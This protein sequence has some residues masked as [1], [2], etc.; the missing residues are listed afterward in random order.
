MTKEIKTWKDETGREIPL[1]Y[2]TKTQK[3]REALAA[4][5]LKLSQKQHD[6]LKELKAQYAAICN[7]VY[8][9]ALAEYNV[10]Q[11]DRKGNFTWFNFD[12]SIK[13]ETNVNAQIKF[14][15]M[16]IGLCKDKPSWTH[17]K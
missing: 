7:E 13:V 5:L 16:L 15:D 3:A 17:Q 6:A 14:D 11:K 8:Q 10:E 2:I 1:S 9:A 4:K 12:R